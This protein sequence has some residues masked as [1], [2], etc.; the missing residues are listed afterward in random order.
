[1]MVLTCR[2]VPLTG[3]RWPK[4]LS[5]E[6]VGACITINDRTGE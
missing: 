1:M 5:G 3:R 2:N 4:M 6:V